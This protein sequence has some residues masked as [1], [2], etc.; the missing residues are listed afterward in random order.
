MVILAIFWHAI[1]Q[2]PMLLVAKKVEKMIK[3]FQIFFSEKKNI[4]Q[5]WKPSFI[6]K[7]QKLA[8]LALSLQDIKNLLCQ[9]MGLTVETRYNEA[10]DLLRFAVEN[11]RTFFDIFAA[12]DYSRDA[13]Q[14]DASSANV[15]R[16]VGPP[17]HN[18]NFRVGLQNCNQIIAAPSVL[19]VISKLQLSQSP[20]RILRF[21]RTFWVT[22]FS[23]KS[24]FLR[25]N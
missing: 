6:K 25:Q 18:V 24:H 13:V 15:H 3:I 10:K 2:P 7:V 23:K 22:K 19:P 8:I 1:W 16:S 4:K 5:V 14:S 12:L 11:Y 17:R 21:S 9:K 20:F